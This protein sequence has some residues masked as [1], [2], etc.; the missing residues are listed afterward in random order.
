MKETWC[1]FDL[2][3]TLIRKDSYLPFLLGWWN[4]HKRRV[5]HISL[6]PIKY[7]QYILCRRERVYIKES[8]L[9]A[10]MRYAKREDIEIFVKLFWDKFL[11][12][13]QNDAVINRLNWHYK[14]GHRV[15]IV[16][17]SFD[18]YAK[19]LASIWPVDGI[20]A[21]KAEWKN[22]VLTGK[23]KGENCRGIQKIERIENE[24]CINLSNISY[25]AYTDSK[26][27]IPLLKYA[28]HAFIIKCSR[29]QTWR[30]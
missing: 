6:L 21:T 11:P 28:E 9:T 19:Y 30:I 26:S 5:F 25:Y 27:D 23:I 29:I 15:Y 4:Y 18:F 16:T 10:F 1:F 24:L 14:N 22:D 12:R 20:I 3:S 7:V 2:D 17:A 8:F 13:Y